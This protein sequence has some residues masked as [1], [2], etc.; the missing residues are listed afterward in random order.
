[1][2][3]SVDARAV[4]AETPPTAP[5]GFRPDIEGMRAIAIVAVVAFHANVPGFSGGFVGVDVFFVISGFLITSQMLRTTD[6]TGFRFGDFYARRIRRLLPAATLVIVA[7]LFASALFQSPIYQQ[8]TATD[9]R[10]AALFVSNMRFADQAT[11]YFQ[12]AIP[13]SPFQQ[14]WSLSVEEQYYFVWPAIFVLALGGIVSVAGQRRRL[15]IVLSAIG[16]LSFAASVYL[17]TANQPVAFFWLAPRAWELAAGAG[18]ALA[19]TALAR[20]SLP[21]MRAA[22]WVGLALIAA[23]IVLYDETTTFPGLA[24]VPPVLG[25]VLLIVAGSASAAA[26]SPVRRLLST[27]PFQA[28][29]RYSYSLYLWHWPVLIIAAE[30][31]EGV[32]T[33]WTYAVPVVLVGVVPL[34]VA[35]HLLV[36]HPIHTSP[37]LKGQVRLSLL[38]GLALIAISVG[39]SFA[40]GALTS[41]S[42][43]AGRAAEA[44]PALDRGEVIATE[45]VPTDLTPPLSP[46]VHLGTPS[47][48]CDELDDT[49]VFGDAGSD[50]RVVLFGDSH[51]AHWSHAY[52]DIA[53]RQDWRFEKS[54][55]GA[56]GSFLFPP[57]KDTSG[58]R[59]W[60][61]RT[62]AELADDPPD[63][64]VLSNY[65]LPAYRRDPES[66][67]EGVRE[68]LGRLPDETEVVVFAENP[69]FATEV[70]V[71]LADNLERT[72]ACESRRLDQLG[73]LNDELESIVTS[74]GGRFIDLES[75]MCV[76]GRCPV[77]IGNTLVYRDKSHVTGEF[78]RSR[79]A[80]LEA[81]LDD[82]VDA[83]R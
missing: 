3:E 20:S 19:G 6:S 82:A 59:E 58:C 65:S 37:R 81:E 23:P 9:A 14:F 57:I 35:A 32:A 2:A 52:E 79:A 60:R 72:S 70:P 22:S 4:P 49:C 69:D 16:S 38:M 83:R 7:T 27:S 77:I 34:A 33:K 68:V 13:P 10:S 66:W 74:E 71:C 54:T 36:E 75:W 18:L 21:L 39:A 73:E 56:C 12:E 11:D 41:G 62:L 40:Y 46:G 28:G 26:T 48:I 55:F 1:V 53:T 50:V 47:T 45:F 8:E 15:A 31:F 51:T 43:D 44:S 5:S 78:A 30:V 67:A 63:V 29:G 76:A 24:A 42:L 80:M 17:T 64:V 25:T 61:D